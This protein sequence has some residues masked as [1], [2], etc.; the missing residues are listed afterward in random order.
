MRKIYQGILARNKNRDST[1]PCGGEDNCL[2]ASKMLS[3]QKCIQSLEQKSFELPAVLSLSTASIAVDCDSANLNHQFSSSLFSPPSVTAPSEEVDNHASTIKRTSDFSKAHVKDDSVENEL[4]SLEDY[5]ISNAPSI[6]KNDYLIDSKLY[7][8]T[9]LSEEKKYNV[10][11][12]SR[13]CRGLH[14]DSSSWKVT[15]FLHNLYHHNSNKLFIAFVTLRVCIQAFF[16]FCSTQLY[17]LLLCVRFLLFDLPKSLLHDLL[18]ISIRLPRVLSASMQHKF[19]NFK[20][21]CLLELSVVFLAVVSALT[22][23]L[24]LLSTIFS[25]FIQP[26]LKT[27]SFAQVPSQGFSNGAEGNK[28]LSVN[29]ERVFNQDY[30]YLM[31]FSNRFDDYFK[32]FGHFLMNWSFVSLGGSYIMGGSGISID[33]TNKKEIRDLLLLTRTR[34]IV[35]G[36]LMLATPFFS[37]VIVRLLRLRA[38]RRL[39][40]AVES[41]RRD[42]RGY[43]YCYSHFMREEHLDFITSS[44]KNMQEVFENQEVQEVVLRPR[45]ASHEEEGQFSQGGHICRSEIQISTEVTDVKNLFSSNK[46][47]C[48]VEKFV[49]NPSGFSL[50]SN[51]YHHHSIACV[52]LDADKF[53]DE[54]FHKYQMCKKTRRVV[55]RFGNIRAL[56]ES[57]FCLDTEVDEELLSFSSL[58]LFIG[59]SFIILGI[60]GCIFVT[61]GLTARLGVFIS[62]VNVGVLL[63]LNWSAAWDEFCLRTADRFVV[64]AKE[65]YDDIKEMFRNKDQ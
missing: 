36:V 45:S 48:E 35:D 32:Y 62:F 54:H 17:L 16:F 15:R 59:I 56:S 29:W 50:D 49:S 12:I 28:N 13:L 5:R 24:P 14:A 7:Y 65:C 41:Y 33:S 3:N 2:S 21:A 53:F 34:C 9:I 11:P 39:Y 52:L 6:S 38:R 57:G 60:G 42:E 30:D 1:L 8:S 40:D 4:E 20:W 10:D 26:F 37:L 51:G 55:P 27:S 61:F 43:Q 25:S 63:M 58:I 19:L 47:D 64:S 23:F 46:I 18:N 31:N 44:N 22:R